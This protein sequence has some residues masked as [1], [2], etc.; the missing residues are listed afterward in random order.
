M[1]RIDFVGEAPV[2]GKTD[3]P[4]DGS[5]TGRTFDGIG[6]IRAVPPSAPRPGR[7]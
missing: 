1:D 5:G 7:R 3:V 6:A 2:P 4:V